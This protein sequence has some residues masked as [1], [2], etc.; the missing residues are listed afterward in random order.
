MKKTLSLIALLM[1]TCSASFADG[2]GE[3]L[4][5][6]CISTHQSSRFQEVVADADAP[7]ETSSESSSR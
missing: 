1:I 2:V 5:A 7:V 4:A 3:N 6:D